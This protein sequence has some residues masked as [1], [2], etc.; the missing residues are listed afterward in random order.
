MRGEIGFE[1]GALRC[2][3]R[4]RHAVTFSHPLHQPMGFLMEASGVERE[5]VDREAMVMDEI[6]KDHILDAETRGERHRFE[7]LGGFAQERECP[8][9]FLVHRNARF[10]PFCILAI[11]W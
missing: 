2:E 3:D 11:Y 1:I 4:D 10:Q 9:Q 8:W 6:R 5:D 7:R